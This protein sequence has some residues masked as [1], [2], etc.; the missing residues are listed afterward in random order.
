M[1]RLY[2]Y[3]ILQISI[4]ASSTNFL[5]MFYKSSIYFGFCRI[6]NVSKRDKIATRTYF[7]TPIFHN[8][9]KNKK[10]GKKI[11]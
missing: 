4:F 7:F 5:V 3:N 1:S 9:N 2:F 10:L 8:E 11:F 6:S